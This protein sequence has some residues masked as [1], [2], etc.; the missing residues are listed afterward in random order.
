MQSPLKLYSLKIAA[1]KKFHV[2]HGGKFSPSPSAERVQLK[3][4]DDLTIHF[5]H[6]SRGLGLS[7]CLHPQLE[8]G[9]MCGRED[10]KGFFFRLSFR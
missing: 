8:P 6:P 1:N 10:E 7:M 3:L 5:K 9:S 2:L 4:I